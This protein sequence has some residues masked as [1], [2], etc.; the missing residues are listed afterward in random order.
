M[1]IAT[2]YRIDPM[3]MALAIGSGLSTGAFAPT[4]LFG[5]VTHG[6]AQRAGVDL[7]PLALFAVA[8]VANSL[9]LAAGFVAFG[10]LALAR[11]RE[12]HSGSGVVTTARLSRVQIVTVCAMVGLVGVVIAASLAGWRSDIGVLCFAFGAA[13]S[14][15]DPASGKSAVSRIDWPTVLMVGGI[16]TYVAVLQKMGAVDLLGEAAARLGSPVVVALAICCTGGLVS[17]FASTTGI[18]AALVPL[19]IPLVASGEIEG[20]ALLSALAVCSS[21]VDISPFSTSGATLVACAAEEDRP[22]LTSLLTRWG[23]SLV[24]IGPVVLVGVLVLPSGL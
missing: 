12:A 14:L 6:V 5:I 19:A 3:L 23:L 16:I 20:W 7:D 11:R 8:A 24:V 21:I 13:L 18:L 17:A 10:G 4:S 2:R 1:P 15:V 9:V 22:R